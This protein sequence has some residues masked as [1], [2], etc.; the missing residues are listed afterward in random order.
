MKKMRCSCCGKQF[1]VGERYF[2]LDEEVLCEDCLVENYMFTNEEE[3][4]PEEES[5]PRY[6][7]EYWEDR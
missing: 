1:E 7:P 2:D 5:D 6:E 3:P 4:E